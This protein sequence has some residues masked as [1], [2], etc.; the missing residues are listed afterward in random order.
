[1]ATWGHHRESP[2]LPD[3]EFPEIEGADRWQVVARAQLATLHRRGTPL[4]RVLP[5]P[6]AHVG[7][8]LFADGTVL[9]GRAPHSGD[10]AVLAVAAARNT[11]HETHRPGAGLVLVFRCG[12]LGTVRVA[13]VGVD[14]PD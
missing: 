9:L 5:S 11:I 6:V 3:I 10:L 13:I 2:S 1:M 12:V 8:L 14:Q 7:R 4:R